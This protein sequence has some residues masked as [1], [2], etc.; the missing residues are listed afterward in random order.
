MMLAATGCEST[1]LDHDPQDQRTDEAYFR[2]P[3]QFKEYTTSLYGQLHGWWSPIEGYAAQMD[4]SS[5]LSAYYG[6]NNDL[7]HGTV[8]VPVTDSRWDRCY[9]NIRKI[10]LLFDNQYRYPGTE[11]EIARWLAEARFFRAYNYF[12]L[13]RYFGGVPIVTSALDVNSPELYAARNSRY[14]VFDLILED[15]TYAVEN[16]PSEALIDTADKGRI[17]FQAAQAFKARV[18]L[19]E[20]TWRKYVGT[21]TDFP[22][23]GTFDP[24]TINDYLTEAVQLCESVINSNM[25]S[26]WNQNSLASMNNMSYRYLFCIEG[27][28]SNPGNFDKSSN[29]EFIIKQLFDTDLKPAG[30]N[31]NQTIGHFSHS[32]KLMDMYVCTDGLPISISP[33]FKGYA[34]VAD[35]YE[36][37]DYRMKSVTD[38]ESQMRSKTLTNGTSGYGCIK[39]IS[40]KATLKEGHDYP[41]MR[42]AEVY[43]N[44]CE[45]L[46]ELNGDV[47]DAQLNKSINIERRRAGIANLSRALVQKIIDLTGTDRPYSEVLREEIRRERAVELYL[48]GFRWD[49]LKRWGIAEQEINTDRLGT[50]VGGV[51]YPTVY[52]DAQGR[53]TSLYAPGTYVWGTGQIDSPWGKLDA[54]RIESKDNIKFERTHYLNPIPQQQRMLNKNLVQNPGY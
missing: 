31:V 44:Y 54:V 39:F 19:Y 16:L 36:N 10:N 50:V 23:S 25:Y 2:T 42:L 34:Q 8:T 12:H 45:A 11:K 35:E 46:W 53:A 1:F 51:G 28:G 52:C 48:E 33:L 47:T 5:D 38:Y 4:V 43:L 26:I 20:A 17:S 41:V 30:V 49:D 15:L 27:A 6:H 9:A 40:S 24:S 14:E 29:K 21:S 32:R 22:G 37:R 3:E 18:L 13:L 7:G